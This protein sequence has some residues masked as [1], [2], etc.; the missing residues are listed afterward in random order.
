MKCLDKLPAT[1]VD[2]ALEY[3]DK[4]SVSIKNGDAILWGITVRDDP[5]IIGT[6]CYWR[7][8][9]EH[10]R[11]EIGYVLHPDYTGKGMMHEALTE[12]LN[13]GFQKMKLHSVEA[14][15]NPHNIPSI[16]ILEKNNFEREAYFKEDYFFDGRFLDTVVYSLLTPLAD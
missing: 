11:A 4:I 7:M 8:E 16:K 10:Y 2:E 12:V 15:V 6:I 1:T 5:K 13:Y 9:K 14:R 3:I